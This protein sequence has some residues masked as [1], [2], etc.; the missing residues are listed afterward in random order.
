MIFFGETGGYRLLDYGDGRKLESFGSVIV[1]R[2]APG[3]T[4]RCFAPHLWQKANARYE[5][6]SGWTRFVPVAEPW[7]IVCEDISFEIR[8]SSGGQIG[9]FPEQQENWRW[10]RSVVASTQRNISILNAFAYT[11]GATLAALTAPTSHRVEVCHLDGS[12]SAVSWARRNAALNDLATAPIR[13]IVDDALSF[14]RREA[15]RGK[16]YDGIILDPPAFGR[17]PRG[18]RWKLG[19]DFSS[20][21]E[22]VQAVLSEDPLFLLLSWHAPLLSAENVLEATGQ[23][24]R[25]VAAEKAPLAIPCEAC[26]P[27]P[28]GMTLRLLF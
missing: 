8:L 15:R 4:N 21:L 5:R 6:G 23:R 27:L 13:W 19:D 11:G 26:P 7:Q 2:P 16:R 18:R 28:A 12:K 20:L 17:G 1:D 3:A 9:V 24:I 14:L 22:A 10:V 25:P